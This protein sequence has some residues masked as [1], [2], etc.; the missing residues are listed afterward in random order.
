MEQIVDVPVPLLIVIVAFP[1]AHLERF[2]T[3]QW[4]SVVIGWL[5][6]GCH[7]DEQAGSHNSWLN[8]ASALQ[9]SD[10]LPWLKDLSTITSRFCPSLVGWVLLC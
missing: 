7:R 8:G 4:D 1:L 9:K 5:E 2:R 10:R 3:A 6:E